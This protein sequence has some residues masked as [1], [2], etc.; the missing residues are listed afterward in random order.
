MAAYFSNW[1][2][3]FYRKG[4]GAVV[5]K[6]CLRFFAGCIGDAHPSLKRK[7]KRFDDGF[8]AVIGI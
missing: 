2:K 1:R 5:I 8:E 6:K 3:L 7:K 4:S